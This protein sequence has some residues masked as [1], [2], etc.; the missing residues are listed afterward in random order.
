MS[1]IQ[2]F[3]AADLARK[4]GDILDAAS[5]A[6]VAITKHRK[7]R[8][9]LMSLERYEALTGTTDQQAHTLEDM[10]AEMKA[11][12]IAALERDLAGGAKPDA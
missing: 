9:V 5:R 1:D 2:N 7:P 4:T 12:M 10:S 8:F 11:M 6:P 3:P